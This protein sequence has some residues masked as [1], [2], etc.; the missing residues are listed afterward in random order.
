MR[1]E[2]LRR[3]GGEFGRREA[4][5]L[6]LMEVG[7]GLDKWIWSMSIG[8]ESAVGEGFGCEEHGVGA[9]EPSAR[10]RLN[11]KRRGTCGLCGCQEGYML[12]IWGVRVCQRVVPPL[13]I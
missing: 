1:A 4:W 7:E 6:F 5:L 8:S 10:I 2:E 9:L 12:I 3:G 13:D 11:V